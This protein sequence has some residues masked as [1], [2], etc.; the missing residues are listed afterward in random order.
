M[1][2]NGD[3]L[4][5]EGVHGLVQSI[6]DNVAQGHIARLSV[7]SP[8]FEHV[9]GTLEYL[10]VTHYAGVIKRELHGQIPFFRC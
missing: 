5:T 10:L 9:G 2:P 3:Y 7:F 6:V 8:C 4:K 1:V